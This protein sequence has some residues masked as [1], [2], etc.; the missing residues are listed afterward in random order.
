MLKITQFDRVTRIDSA[1]T[2]AGKGYYWSTAYLVDG[3]LVDT[4]CAHTAC[5]LSE[6]LRREPISHII[7]THSH[8]DHIGGNGILQEQ[9]KEVEIFA[10]PLALPV[11]E[12][13]QL[14]QPL[15][16]YELRT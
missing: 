10:H 11:L 1:R 16:N 8:E 15:H 5:E 7:N 6:T 12:N 2:I 4:G 13:P 3:L 14:N 9:H